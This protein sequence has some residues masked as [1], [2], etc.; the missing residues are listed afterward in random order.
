HRSPGEYFLVR[1]PALGL[2]FLGADSAGTLMLSPLLD[3]PQGRWKAGA[4]LAA[5]SVF[6]QL[7]AEAKASKG[8]PM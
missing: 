2:I 3:D 5:D 7:V 6:S 1:I 4:T 8:L